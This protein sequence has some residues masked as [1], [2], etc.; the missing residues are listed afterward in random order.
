[1]NS[2]PK[3][4]MALITTLVLMVM[5]TAIAIKLFTRLTQQTTLASWEQ[6]NSQARWYLASAE[7]LALSILRQSLAKETRVYAGQAWAATPRRFPVPQG[8]IAVT[9]SDRQ[10]CFNLNALANSDPAQ[11]TA[12]REQLATLLSYLNVPAPQAEQLV[13]QLGQWFGADKPPAVAERSDEITLRPASRL[14]VESS[15]LRDLEGM[16]AGLY[17]K[18]APFVCALPQTYQQLN[19]NTLNAQQSV[20]LAA[21]LAPALSVRQARALIEHRPAEGWES[22]AQF[23]N[24]SALA[25]IDGSVKETLSVES[26]YFQLRAEVT[27]ARET[28]HTRALIGRVAD[29]Q[30]SI[31][32]HQ[33]GEPE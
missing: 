33:T 4:G 16:D 7:S 24:Q 8:A 6:Q 13:E 17:K 22:V 23:L 11:Q 28:L 20:I 27:F 14:L 29:K 25:A 30:F 9:L 32:W 15:E 2:R 1:M 18:I 19:I 5:M 3:R 21:I 12:A 26:R 31:L 10:S